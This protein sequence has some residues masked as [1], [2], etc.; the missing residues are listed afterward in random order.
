[1][2]KSFTK[3]ISLV[4]L[5]LLLGVNFTLAQNEQELKKQLKQQ[6][7]KLSESGYNSQEFWLTLHPNWGDNDSSGKIIVYVS[8]PVKTTITLEIPAL[9]IKRQQTAVPNDIIE[10]VLKP[11]Q[12]QMYLKNVSMKM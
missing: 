9:G 4:L 5:M 12:V 2:K 7:P 6:L 11:S 3:F 1:M 10:F 8:C